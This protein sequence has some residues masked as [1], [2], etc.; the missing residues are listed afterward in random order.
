MHVFA[1]R[2]AKLAR[3][4]WL[5]LVV[6][7][8]VMLRVVLESRAA[9]QD[10]SHALARRDTMTAM[11]AFRRAAQWYAPLS[12][13]VYWSLDQL[14]NIARDA[15]ARGDAEQALAAWRSIRA[16]INSTR[17]LYTPHAARLREANRRI[18]L[19]MS[20]LPPAPI[21]AARDQADLEQEFLGQ[22][23]RD[24]RPSRLWAGLGLMGFFAWAASMS[25][26][27]YWGVTPE[28]RLRRREA[29]LYGL[30]GMLSFALF[31][32]GMRLA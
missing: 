30:L 14:R 7:S 22:L 31:A 11:V 25:A 18:A 16:G 27:F 32:L 2:R 4:G 19:L 12:P 15:E 13:Y 6:V 17:S 29:S 24:K 5:A 21:D 10:G 20:Q 26:F 23:Q 3:L 28:G 9:W 8:V 1:T